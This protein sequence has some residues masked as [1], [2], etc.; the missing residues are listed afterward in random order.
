MTSSA[1]TISAEKAQKTLYF[2]MM[3]IVVFALD[4]LTK[5][6]VIKNFMLHQ[7]VEVIPGFFNL[8]Y[9]RN[10]G[11]AFGIL[12]GTGSW[13]IYFFLFMG[14]VALLS[15]VIFFYSNYKD[16]LVVMGTALICGGAAGNITDR[17]RLGY[18]VDFLDFFIKDYHWPAFNVADSAITVG[19]LIL[20]IHF[21]KQEKD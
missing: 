6:A 3:A 2:L 15:L 14:A 1:P 16:P 7:S 5:Q 9:V 12:A 10:T 8:T 21:L 18:V 11:A 19:V 20:V 17:I 13:R 4:Q